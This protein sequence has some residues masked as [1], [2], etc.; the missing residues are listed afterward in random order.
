MSVNWEHSS[1]FY[2]QQTVLQMELQT[3][4]DDGYVRW[5]QEG[6]LIYE[7]TTADML[8]SKPGASDTAAQIL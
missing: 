4:K 5:Y 2:T 8:E 7:T 6:K 3:G 1:S